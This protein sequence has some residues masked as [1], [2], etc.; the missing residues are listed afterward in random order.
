MPWIGA[1]TGPAGVLDRIGALT[2]AGAAPYGPNL[3]FVEH[4]AAFPPS[5]A[6][7]AIYLDVIEGEET[8]QAY[9]LTESESGNWLCLTTA[10]YEPAARA[11]FATTEEA[12]TECAGISTDT[13][14]EDGSA[15]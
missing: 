15:S 11:T 8:E 1:N 14:E 6:V 10:G 7:G 4:D 5:T 9:L 13:E 3:T 12:I 2:A